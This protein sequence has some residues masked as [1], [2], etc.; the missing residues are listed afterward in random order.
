MKWCASRHVSYLVVALGSTIVASKP[1][2]AADSFYGLLWS[3]D[4]SPFAHLSLDMRPTHTI[5]IEPGAWLLQTQIAYQNTW[6]MSPAVEEYLTGL[7]SEGRRE[8][9]GAEVQAIRELPGENYLIDIDSTLLDLTF[10]YQFSRDWSGYL[11]V[12]VVSYRHGFLDGAI[13]RFHNAF[14]YSSHGRPTARRHDTNLILDLKSS[15][16]TYLDR[17]TDGGFADP[18][19]GVRY[20]GI[21]MPGAWNLALEAAVKVPVFGERLLLST[22]RADYGVQAS[23]QRFWRRHALYM[24]VAAIYYGGTKEPIPQK[25]QVMPT[26]ILGCELRVT[27]NTNVNLETYISESAYTREITDLDSLRARKYE[28]TIGLRHRLEAL[29]LA[30]GIT[31]NVQNLNNTAD[32]GVHVGFTYLPRVTVTR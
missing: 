29:V 23:L 13:E 20:T 14:G 27:A 2:T 3:R 8:L 7:E 28:I 18:T 22:G 30:F 4:V 1:A 9:G 12:S 15:Q 16:A 11:G 24:D 21:A 32:I 5:K 6:A 31:E 17:P 26:L 19:I 25:A 10:D